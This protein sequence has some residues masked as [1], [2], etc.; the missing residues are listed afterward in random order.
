VDGEWQL[1]IDYVLC[2]FFV[3]I[4]VLFVLFFFFLFLFLFLFLLLHETQALRLAPIDADDKEKNLVATLYLNR[5]SVLHVSPNLISF[6]INLR[7]GK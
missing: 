7:K 2:L 1:Y 3:F 6:I 4:D 5:A